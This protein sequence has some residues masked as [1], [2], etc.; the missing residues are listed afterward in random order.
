MQQQQQQQ[1]I[2]LPP[3]SRFFPSRYTTDP[4]HDIGLRVGDDDASMLELDAHG[5]GYGYG[6]GHGSGRKGGTDWETS[7]KREFL[8]LAEK[9]ESK[10]K[11]EW[12]GKGITRSPTEERAG[13]SYEIERGL[14]EER[15]Q[16][17]SVPPPL[18]PKPTSLVST[19]H[20]SQPQASTL[21]SNSGTHTHPHTDTQP[22]HNPNHH[23]H[24]NHHHTHAHSH[25]HHSHPIRRETQGVTPLQLSLPSSSSVISAQPLLN[26]ELVPGAVLKTESVCLTLERAL[27]E[28]AFSSVWLAVDNSNILGP[29]SDDLPASAAAAA[30][31]TASNSA[32]ASLP[33][34]PQ[35]QSQ[36]SDRARAAASSLTTDVELVGTGTK[37]RRKSESRAKRESDDVRM[38]GIRPTSLSSSHAHSLGVGVGSPLEQL[39]SDGVRNVVCDEG[40]ESGT[41]EDS[42]VL[43]EMDGEGASA[44]TSIAALHL[45][46][47]LSSEKHDES[48]S[49]DVISQDKS[50][51]KKG[52]ESKINGKGR[53]VAV[54]TMNRAMCDANDR[55][56]TSFVRE[57]EVLRVRIPIHLL[58]RIPKEN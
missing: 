52:E 18:P 13:F 25:S 14:S 30:S 3:L 17:P 8:S 55:T 12:E 37:I 26:D 34:L 7:F 44:S 36:L 33:L 1:P 29:D 6:H 4:T 53:L 50:H 28:G 9:A 42:I 31:F 16:R 24:H 49:N 41:K 48:P 39:S 5:N 23:V 20:I 10:E 11:E 38:C 15:I 43:D 57:V 19:P 46:L 21:D 56:R 2:R 47:H 54:K 22:R 35:P 45:P 32:S 27:G 40:G 58:L 51:S